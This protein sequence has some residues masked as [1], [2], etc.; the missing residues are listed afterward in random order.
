MKYIKGT[1]DCG[2]GY[3]ANSEFRLLGYADSDCVGSAK[4][5]KITSG[6]CF[7]LGSGVISWISRN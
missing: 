6:F 7:S 4:D 1:L 5:K 2:L 3:E